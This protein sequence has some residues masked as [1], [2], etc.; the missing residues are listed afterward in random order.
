MLKLTRMKHTGSVGRPDT[1]HEPSSANPTYR[2]SSY[3]AYT[4]PADMNDNARPQSANLP[5]DADP[6]NWPFGLNGILGNK[7]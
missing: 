4:R 5:R 1:A 7:L 3:G 6:W 2:Q